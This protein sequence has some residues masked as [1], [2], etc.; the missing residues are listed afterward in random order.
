M[1]KVVLAN[2]QIQIQPVCERSSYTLVQ[3]IRLHLSAPQHQSISK[4]DP[5]AQLL[6][7]Q[8]Y[9]NQV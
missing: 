6:K 7:R 9:R 4:V 3:G 1:P 2:L 5:H 8:P